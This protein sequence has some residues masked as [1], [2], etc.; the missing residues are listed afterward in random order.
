MVNENDKIYIKTEC[1]EQRLR[2]GTFESDSWRKEGHSRRESSGGIWFDSA[3]LPGSYK[4]GYG[5]LYY[6]VSGHRREF[7][8]FWVLKKW[9]IWALDH[10]KR[11]SSAHWVCSVEMWTL[12]ITQM[13]SKAPEQASKWTLISVSDAQWN[14][15]MG[16]KII[17]IFQKMQFSM[18]TC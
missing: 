3:G 10:T 2:L 1:S 12:M 6:T 5:R 17:L 16:N 14:K 18:F 7:V 13:W 11:S 15:M 4:W 9:L 8:G